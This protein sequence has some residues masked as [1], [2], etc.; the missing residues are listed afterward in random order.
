MRSWSKIAFGA[1]MGASILAL[2]AASASAAIVCSGDVCWHTQEIYRYPGEAHVIVHPDNWRWVTTGITAHG[3]QE[4]PVWG[5]VF[6]SI[7]G[8]HQAEVQLRINNLTEYVA[9]LQ[10]K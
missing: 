10:K 7:S 6:R 1:M 2:S 4:M 8:G 9:S 3:S 5:P